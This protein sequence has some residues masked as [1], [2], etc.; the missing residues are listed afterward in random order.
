MIGSSNNTGLIGGIGNDRFGDDVIYGGVGDDVIF[1]GDGADQ[2][3]YKAVDVMRG[4]DQI[5]DFDAE[6]G[7][8]LVVT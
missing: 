4:S 8:T 6:E 3:I 2:F 7:D 5:K 1:G